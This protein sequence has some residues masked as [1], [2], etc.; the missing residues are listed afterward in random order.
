MFQNTY[1]T[2]DAELVQIAQVFASGL[3]GYREYTLHDADDI[4]Q[5]LILAG[6]LAL[7]RFDPGKASRP[8]F[9]FGVLRDAAASLARRADAGKRD[10]RKEL[11]SLDAEWPDG[12]GEDALWHDAI[13]LEKTVNQDG[14]VR[15]N[16]ADLESLRIDVAAAIAELPPVLQNLALLHCVLR[17]EEAR[18]AAGMVNSTHQR[19][20]RRIRKVFVRRKIVHDRWEKKSGRNRKTAA[21]NSGST[22]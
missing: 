18:R 19:A 10:R 20:I 14:C 7:N 17:S 6:Y 9:L 4:L 11:L 13:G 1:D 2:Y 3:I 5:T 22:R 8:T 21:D 15:N 16:R 12:D